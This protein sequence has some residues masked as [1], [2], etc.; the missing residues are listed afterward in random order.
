MR[1]ENALF[2]AAAGLCL[3]L[4][5][6]LPIFNP[7]L[8]WHLSAGRRIVELGAIPKTDWL[9]STRA[10]APWIDFEWLSQLLFYAVHRAAGLPGLLAL[11]AAL[12]LLLA[13]L[14]WALIRARV[15]DGPL[16]P[17]AL[18]LWAAAVLPFAD[19]R[20]DLFSALGF[21]LILLALERRARVR[22]WH[23]LPFFC[24]W[25]N[26]HGGWP[27]GL[28]LLAVYAARDKKL[29]PALAFALAGACVQPGGPA[30][31]SV[32]VAHG[33]DLA[34]LS[35]HIR[36]WMPASPANPWHRPFF[37]ILAAT[38]AALIVRARRRGAPALEPVLVDAGLAAAALRHVRLAFFFP[39][40]CAAPAAGWARE[41]LPARAARWTAALACAAAIA[42][43]APLAL[44]VGTFRVFVR[45]Q[46][47]EGAVEFLDRNAAVFGGRTV[48]AHTWQWGGLLGFRLY[49]RYRVYGDGRYIFHDLVDRTRRATSSPEAWRS[50]LDGEK[51]DLVILEASGPVFAGK[52]YWVVFMP[53]ALWNP[54]YADDSAIVFARRTAFAQTRGASFR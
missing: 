21:S 37:F 52:P 22:P 29:R 40:A 47:V 8:Y 49:P 4:A 34:A 3:I 11:K 30:S 48:Y 16:A 46:G 23:A 38:A 17:A 32:L 10:G 18:A 28:A 12:V 20:P 33:R 7:D 44:S 15:P 25:A 6:A 50:F 39:L 31:L 19:L 45:G 14:A 2:G 36:E 24:V 9:S 43:A 1:R 41:A 53:P 35:A 51:L 54:V 27:Y 26:L 42:L 5:A 13:R